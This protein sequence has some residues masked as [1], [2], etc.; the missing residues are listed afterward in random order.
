MGWP[1]SGRALPFSVK[2]DRAALNAAR[3]AIEKSN[4]AMAV[5]ELLPLARKGNASA[6]YYLAW[7]SHQGRGLPENN[8][9]ALAWAR[10]A[11]AQGNADAEFLIGLLY[12]QGQGVARDDVEAARWFQKSAAQGNWSGQMK[13]GMCHMCGLGLPLDYLK[14]Y[15]WLDL[16]TARSTGHDQLLNRNLRD[17]HA[18]MHLTP[19][20]IAEAQRLARGWKPQKAPRPKSPQVA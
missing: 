12:A 4:Y 15:M 1:Y 16:A 18:A 5:T 3:Q 13:T 11:A 14:A 2:S 17:I 9:A 7:M 20:Q 19:A 10:K 6:Q 8:S